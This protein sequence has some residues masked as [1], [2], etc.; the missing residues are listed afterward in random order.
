MKIIRDRPKT[1]ELEELL[2]RPLFAHL[3]TNSPGGPR[4]SPVWFLW[5]EGAI[6]ILGNRRTDT[7]PTR[8]EK[9]PRCALG[10]IDSDLGTGRVHHGGFRGRAS[11]R[12]FDRRLAIRLLSK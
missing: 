1:I 7:F 9:E 8:I 6:W 12:P 3:A 4:E 2:A 11:I 10:I 5:E